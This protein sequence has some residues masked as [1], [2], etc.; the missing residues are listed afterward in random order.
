[1]KARARSSGAADH[2]NLFIFGSRS[3]YESI[4]RPG[5][6]VTTISVSER[7]LT[8]IANAWGIWHMGQFAA[9]DRRQFG[10]R[11]SEMVRRVRGV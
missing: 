5:F 8:D 9:D 1:M 10:A 7:H 4:T 2:R 6:S 11:P 3:G